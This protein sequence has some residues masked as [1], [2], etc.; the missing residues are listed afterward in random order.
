MWFVVFLSSLARSLT[1]CKA[2]VVV[3][4]DRRV[5]LNMDKLFPTAAAAAAAAVGAE[6][7]AEAI[8]FFLP[9]REAHKSLLE[10]K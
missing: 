10:G 1:T 2:T 4:V 7:T 3:V 5:T 6:A 9:K 8:F